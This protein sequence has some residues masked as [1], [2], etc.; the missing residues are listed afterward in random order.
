MA[1][2]MDKQL[3]ELG[4][5]LGGISATAIQ[6]IVND[7]LTTEE[8]GGDGWKTLYCNKEEAIKL[9]D[10]IQNHGDIDQAPEGYGQLLS[11]IYNPSLL[12]LKEVSGRE[13][14]Y[15]DI[16]KYFVECINEFFRDQSFN[17]EINDEVFTNHAYS[18][19][20]GKII[21]H[22]ET[23]LDDQEDAALLAAA[24]AA[25]DAADAAAAHVF[26]G[27]AAAA[28]VGGVFAPIAMA[29]RV[30]RHGPADVGD[31]Q[32]ADLQAAIDASLQDAA[33]AHVFHGPAAEGSVDR[34]NIDWLVAAIHNMG[35]GDN[36]GPNPTLGHLQDMYDMFVSLV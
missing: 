7:A 15:L 3:S 22:E 35:Y 17:L 20:N 21:K 31:L 13:I 18:G 9:K 16:R 5:K 6:S 19:D 32:D 26:H 34:E 14:S 33:A 30:I 24:I 23:Q 8:K 27:P 2:A 12:N 10:I 28:H 11:A 36:I 1:Q 29:G 25:M 4:K